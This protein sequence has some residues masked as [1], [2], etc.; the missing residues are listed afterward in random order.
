MHHFRNDYSEGA[1]PLVMQA[2]AETNLDRTAGYGEDEYC[3]AAAQMARERFGCPD[4]AVHFLVGGTQANTV[5]I[6]ALLR[7]WEAALTVDTGHIAVHE[8]GSIEA[9]GHKVIT[10]LG[11]DGKIL[12]ADVVS[13]MEAHG[14]G[15][16]CHMV[17]PKLLYLS[18]STEVG[19]VYTK[20]ELTALRQ[21]CDQYGLYLYLDG[22]RLASALAL[23]DGDLSPEDLPKLCDA[24]TLGGTKIG[25]LFGECLIITNPELA[26]FFRSCMKQHGGLLAKGRLLGVQFRA[27][28]E[29]DLWLQMGR[30][31]N[32]LAAKLTKAL[33]DKGYTLFAQSPTNQVFPVVTKEK[34]AALAKD[35]TFEVN[36]PVDKDHDCIR[37][38]TS[39]ATEEEAVDALIAAL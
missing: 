34:E 2:L 23:E 3:A 19:T 18:D 5:I 36:G 24:F 7:P 13:V 15:M 28:L 31:E 26:P 20:A 11:H 9:K 21:V 14:S 12:P 35:F 27:L 22:A 6:T 33:Q 1:H 10:V 8:T 39:W 37:F 4:A 30:H 38:V 25:L 17:S 32:R 16:N 29:N